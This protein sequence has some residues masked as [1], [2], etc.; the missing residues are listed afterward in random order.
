MFL[1]E[2]LYVWQC[3]SVV[4]QYIS[5]LITNPG[6]IVV[7]SDLTRSNLGPVPPAGVSGLVWPDQIFNYKNQIFHIQILEITATSSQCKHPQSALIINQHFFGTDP[8]IHPPL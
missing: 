5:S 8:A 1:S 7:V 6:C 3:G 4:V 2:L